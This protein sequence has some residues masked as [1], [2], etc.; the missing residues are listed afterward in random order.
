[1]SENTTPNGSG[2]LSVDTAVNAFMGLMDSSEEAP[3]GESEEQ[4]VT[5]E[6]EA[7]DE[8]EQVEEQAEEQE[9]PTTFRVK[10]A[11][12]EREVT[13]DELIEGYQLGADY[14]KKTQSLSEQRKAVEAERAKIEE[15]AKLRDQYAQRLQLMEKILQQQNKGENL[16]V[17]KETDPIG[18]AV[19]VAEQA[20]RDKQLLALQQEQQRI[21]QQQQ[22]EQAERLQSHIAEE[23]QKLA[24]AI[25]GYAD[26]KQ[27]DQIRKDIR[28]YA[29]SIGWTDQEL[30]NIYDSRAVLSLY[31]GMQYAKLQSKKPEVTKKVNEAPKTMKTG[32][33]QP[34]NAESDAQK[35]A[36]AQLR[37]SGKVTDAALAFQRFIT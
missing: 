6:A 3:Q 36:L 10:A 22:A 14:T 26:P 35:K 13:L 28:E 33:S 32:V 25:P 24:K 30:A 16:E 19:K 8:T 17:L 2:T 11:G 37:K 27:G 12:E 5:Q 31:Q 21:A 9:Q 15:A 23:S 29:K 4:E 18:Y 20:Q 7:V 1:M 34:R